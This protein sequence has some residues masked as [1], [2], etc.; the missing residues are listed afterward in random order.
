MGLGLSIARSIVRAHSGTIAAAPRA[1]G[2][3][4]FTILLTNRLPRAPVLS[5]H[6]GRAADPARLPTA[7]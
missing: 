5:A 3:A 4:E 7:A 1:G 2:G 6:A